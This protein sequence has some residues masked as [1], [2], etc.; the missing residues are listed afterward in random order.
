MFFKGQ[1]CPHK[2]FIY[3]DASFNPQ[4]GRAV[5]GFLYFNNEM[6]HAKS[7]VS[8]T[9]IE[10]QSFK[11]KNNIRAEIM[12]A[13][14]CLNKLDE[15]V[16]HKLFDIK[17]IEVN[18]YSDCQAL[19]NLLRRRENLIANNFMS[20]KKKT[21]LANADLYKLFYLIF[22]RVK[23]KIHWVMGHSASKDQNVVQSIVQR[24]FKIIDHYVRTE[25]RKE[26]NE[27]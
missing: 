22:D 11:V 14:Y 1:F 24:N 23:P 15:E 18:I 13:I 25:L 6:L 2:I 20:G 5:S 17:N 10:T 12:G 21:E 16:K 8:D 7:E 3:T 27:N 19:T 9:S 4:T 26:L